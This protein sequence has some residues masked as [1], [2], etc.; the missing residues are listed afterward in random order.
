MSKGITKGIIIRE[1]EKLIEENGISHFSLH[2]LAQR[3]HI[4]TASLYSHISGMDEILEEASMDIL[5][6]YHDYQMKTIKEKN[7]RDALL[8]LAISE[9]T[10]AQEHFSFYDL[11]MNLQLS[12][13]ERLK[14]EASCL[15]QPIMTILDQYDL[16]QNQ[17]VNAER[18]FRAS[19]FGFISQE[20]HKYFSH[21]SNDTKES[22]LFCINTII[23]GIEAMKHAE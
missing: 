20:K 5:H 10:Y 21:L 18:A 19:V 14:E 2:V 15:I 11:I 7:G 12:D 22:F 13:N 16:N 8:S 3:L 6:Q 4:K 1:A 17:K 9:R 23:D